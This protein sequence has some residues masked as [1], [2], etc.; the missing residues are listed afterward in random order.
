M[1]AGKHMISCCCTS[2]DIIRREGLL[3]LTV[4]FYR[5]KTSH[6]TSDDN[7]KPISP[8]PSKFPYEDNPAC[9]L[10]C[11]I[12]RGPHSPLRGGSVNNIYVIPAPD[13]LTFGAAT[14]LAAACCIPAILS[15]ISMWNKILENNWKT[16]FGGGDD[17]DRIDEA[18][19]GT[20][21]AT[22][23]KM[24]DVNNRIK[25][26][27]EVVGI[28]LFGGAVLAI[29]I[30]GERNLFSTQ[31]R[32]QTEPMASIGRFMANHAVVSKG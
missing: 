21:G 13:K 7:G 16:R 27:L 14:L 4:E 31:V 23:R 11:S 26:F 30:V 10:T 28:P 6:C 25:A 22:V 12:E 9:G 17:E 32:Y 2:N 24:R 8:R 1:L 19:E 3:S 15:L 18:I 20:N 5:I 29:L